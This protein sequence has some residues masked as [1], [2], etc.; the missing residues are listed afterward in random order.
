MTT[1]ITNNKKDLSDIDNLDDLKR[2][3][4]SLKKSI[5][6]Q[7]QELEERLTRLPQESMKA[8]V[9]KV[10]PKVV[11][12]LVTGKSIGLVT[13]VAG[14]LLGKRSFKKSAAK[15]GTSVIAKGVGVFSALKGAYSLWKKRKPRPNKK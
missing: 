9:G 7:E 6:I 1:M 12:G 13:S 11:G 8:T 10:V 14:F 4:T 2:E 15:A 3:I 5:N